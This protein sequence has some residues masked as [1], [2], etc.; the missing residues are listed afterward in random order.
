VQTS[1]VR[2]LRI[3]LLAALGC[4]SIASLDC[5]GGG[6]GGGKVT[7]TIAATVVPAATPPCDA[8]SRATPGQ[9]DGPY[10]KAG[11][12]ERA[13][14]IEAAT[15]GTRLTLS[16]AVLSTDCNRIAGAVL[17]FWQADSNGVYDNDGFR[18]RGH[19]TTDAAGR[20]KLET[21]IPGLYT[22]RT[23]HIHVKISAPN[24]PELTTQLYFAGVPEN[25]SDGIFDPAL[26]ITTEASGGAK[27]GGF[28]FVLR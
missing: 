1:H 15:Q 7:A 26:V 10:F 11:S 9:T 13:S 24:H 20:Y 19:Q 4:A 2:L 21:I 8:A 14:L 5:G 12:P 6:S 18:L 23:E 28:D 16:G 22:G 17:D 3:A 27:V 25:A